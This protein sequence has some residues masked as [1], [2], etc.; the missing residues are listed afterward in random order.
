VA[1]GMGAAGH[2]Q[3]V[4]PGL[5]P[6]GAMPH[7]AIAQGAVYGGGMAMDGGSSAVL[8]ELVGSVAMTVLGE[9]ANKRMLVNAVRDGGCNCS[10]CACQQRL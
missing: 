9:P 8:S 2:S 1:L 10:G 5:L 7:A 6:A 4:Q 3:F